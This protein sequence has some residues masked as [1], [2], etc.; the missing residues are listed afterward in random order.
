[1]IHKILFKITI[2]GTGYLE[3]DM[4]KVCSQIVEL[5]GYV[6]LLHYLFY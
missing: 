2:K 1:M 4:I 5:L 6:V 3:K